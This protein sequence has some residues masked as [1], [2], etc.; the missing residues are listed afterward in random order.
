MRLQQQRNNLSNHFNNI[1]GLGIHA[2]LAI[3]IALIT[4]NFAYQ[5][6]VQDQQYVHL[7]VAQKT[8][9]KQ[10]EQQ[11]TPWIGIMLDNMTSNIAKSMG[12]SPDTRGALVL[13]VKEGGPAAIAGIEGSKFKVEN[14]SA[15]LEGKPE[16][17]IIIRIDNDTITGAKD[18]RPAIREKQV[19]DILKVWI[20]RD[21]EIQR[22]NLT[23]VSC[24]QSLLGTAGCINK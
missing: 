6:N 24:P 17:D 7:A 10:D 11:Q 4:L 19:G 23:I 5:N 18:V 8:P 20:I 15:V 21:G 3:I 13:A 16:G 1:A 12:L 9:Q 22:I 2:L 14:K